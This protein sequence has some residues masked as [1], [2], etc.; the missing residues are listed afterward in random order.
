MP[1]SVSLRSSRAPRVWAALLGAAALAA[2][3]DGSPLE[4]S[5]G[6][7]SLKRVAGGTATVSATGLLYCPTATTQSASRVIGERGGKVKAGGT[8]LD[9]PAGAVLAPTEFTVTVPASEYMEVDIS[10]AGH[11]HF[12]FQRP[13]TVEV[14][15]KR[16]VEPGQSLPLSAWY[17]DAESNALL[18]SMQVVDEKA[19]RKLTFLTTH[20]SGYF[21]AYR[22]AADAA[23][24]TLPPDTLDAPGLNH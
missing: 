21:L 5:S 11:E 2:C 23:P 6:A 18:E 19:N 10:A 1:K 15:Y 22:N 9:V 3:S 4:P 16:C 14:S 13:V 12:T 8:T 17:V 7:P 24:D 20:L